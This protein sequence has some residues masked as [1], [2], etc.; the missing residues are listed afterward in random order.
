M[1]ILNEGI[2]IN[3]VRKKMEKTSHILMCSIML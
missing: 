1:K 3:K 2:F